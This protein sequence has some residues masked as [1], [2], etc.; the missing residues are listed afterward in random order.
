[1][2]LLVARVRASI[3][4]DD[5]NIEN[6]D[7]DSEDS[8]HDSDYVEL[9]TGPLEWISN[10]GRTGELAPL[11]LAYKKGLNNTNQIIAMS[12]C[13]FTDNKTGIAYEIRPNTFSI[14]TKG[15]GGFIKRKDLLNLIR[16]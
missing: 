2:S 1:M 8:N 10:D 11:L 13:T 6:G 9:T 5:G 4:H 3:Q 14:D 12:S 16:Q 15:L 7:S